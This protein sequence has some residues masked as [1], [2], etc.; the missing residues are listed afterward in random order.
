MDDV[1]KLNQAKIRSKNGE[2][3]IQPNLSLLE[4]EFKEFVPLGCTSRVSVAPSSVYEET[5]VTV[6]F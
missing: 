6:D 2:I 1:I 3:S 4:L 5:I